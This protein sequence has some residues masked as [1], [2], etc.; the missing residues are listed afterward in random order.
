MSK[1]SPDQWER[2]FEAA[3]DARARAYAPYSNFQVGAALLT[4]AGEI[5]PGCNVEN[6]TYGATCCAERTAVYSAVANGL[7][8]FIAMVVL[9][10]AP[11]PATSCGVCRQVLAEFNP[12]MELR[13]RNLR[14]DELRH[15][16]SDLLP[17]AFTLD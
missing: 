11:R 4:A 15:L 8:D 16:V 17:H 2:L 1:P 9:T 13:F 5:V 6:A 14:G 3:G 7:E 12:A 10:D